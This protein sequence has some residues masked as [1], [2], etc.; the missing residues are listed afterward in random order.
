MSSDGGVRLP[1][2]ALLACVHR[3]V[4]LNTK[5]APGCT[6][7]VIPAFAQEMNYSRSWLKD[8]SQVSKKL[9]CMQ[10]SVPV[11]EHRPSLSS[12]KSRDFSKGKN[13]CQALSA[14]PHLHS[15]LWAQVGIG[16]AL[17]FSRQIAMPFFIRFLCESLIKH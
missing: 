1:G 5:R 9:K 8:P 15:G 2:L 4:C 13:L 10:M 11:R 6:L 7:Q 14:Q 3:R 16:L 17:K 12:D